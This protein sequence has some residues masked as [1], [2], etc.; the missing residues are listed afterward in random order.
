MMY[1]VPMPTRANGVKL[2]TLPNEQIAIEYTQGKL[3]VGPMAYDSSCGIMSRNITFRRTRPDYA[4]IVADAVRRVDAEDAMPRAGI[5]RNLDMSNEEYDSDTNPEAAMAK[6]MDFLENII[7][8]DDLEIV[9]ALFSGAADVHEAREAQATSRRDDDRRTGRQAAD[10]ATDRRR[11]HRL[12]ADA[13]CHR[14][15]SDATEAEFNR[16][17][18]DANRLLLR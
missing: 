13:A 1:K 10:Q 15:M 14:P 9:Q 6:V 12:A 4:A 11:A 16:M 7:S 17:F 18:P 5:T 3:H 8:P 2:H